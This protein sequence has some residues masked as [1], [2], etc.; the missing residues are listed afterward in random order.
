MNALILVVSVGFPVF[1]VVGFLFLAILLGVIID[2]W[3]EMLTKKD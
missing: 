3:I 1:F 2:E